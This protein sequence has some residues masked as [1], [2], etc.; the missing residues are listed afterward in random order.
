MKKSSI[1][2][3]FLLF[4]L[5]ISCGEKTE[6]QALSNNTLTSISKEI[7]ITTADGINLSATYTE[8]AYSSKAV[9]LLHMV[10]SDKTAYQEFTRYLQQNSFTVL[11]IDFRGHGKSELDYKKFTEADWQ[12]FVLDVDAGVDYLEGK[13]YRN[14]G[15]VGA[16]IGANAGFKQAVQDDRIDT[17]VLLSAGESYKGINIL[18]LVPYYQKPVLFVASMDDKDA[19]VAATKLYNALGT[20]QKDLKMYQAGGHGTDLLK[21]QDGLPAIIVT[22]LQKWY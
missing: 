12:N 3:L 4:I 2:F 17:L 10:G 21:N 6:E 7:T 22:W 8:A 18:D 9:L 5:L 15:V 13:G 16:S 20:D 19:A 11:A 1:I 14:I